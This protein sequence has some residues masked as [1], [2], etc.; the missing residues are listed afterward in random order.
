VQ[1]ER[2]AGEVMEH[3]RARRPHAGPETRREDHGAEGTGLCHGR[4]RISRRVSAFT[5]ALP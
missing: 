4:R 2:P 1:Q 5:H 3:L